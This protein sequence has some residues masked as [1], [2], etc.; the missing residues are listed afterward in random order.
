MAVSYMSALFIGTPFF[1]GNYVLNA[2]LSASGDTRSFRN[3]LVGGF[4]LNLLL[5][6]WFIY[7]G[8]GL[9]PLGL[10]G[11][12]WSTILIQFVGNCYMLKRA[13]ASG[14]LSRR[15][16]GMLYPAVEPYRRLFGQGI[17]AS[18]NMLT[19]S[20]GIF[21]ITWFIGRYGAATVAAFG[22]GT[23]IEQVAIL[24]VMGLNI[25]TLTLVAQNYGAANFARVR[26]VQRTALRAGFAITSCGTLLV[27][28]FARYLLVLFTKDPEVIVAGEQYLRIAALLMGAYVVMYINNAALQGLQKPLFAIWIGIYRQLVAPLVA[29][30]LLAVML[31]YGVSGVWW[32]VFSVNWSAALISMLYT[33]HVMRCV[34]E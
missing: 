14:L 6:P 2:I 32:G 11:I 8:F 15:S 29:F 10:P 33:R 22:I 21:V 30:W 31:G 27:F 17:P 13:T 9:P 18:L 24:P 26:L 5:D 23:R 12:A 34:G 16:W 25:A 20:L 28:F 7:G 3:F 1:L 19:V 4:A